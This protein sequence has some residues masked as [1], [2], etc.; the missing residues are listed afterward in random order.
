ML[1]QDPLGAQLCPEES[2][3][4]AAACGGVEGHICSAGLFFRAR[5]LK[6]SGVSCWFCLGIIHHETSL[7]SALGCTVQ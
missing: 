1:V 6:A 4:R 3:D 5:L 7:S 2:K